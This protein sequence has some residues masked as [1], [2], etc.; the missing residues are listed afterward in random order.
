MKLAIITAA[1]KRHKLFEFFCEYYSVLKQA[2]PFELIVACS[3]KETLTLAQKYGHTALMIENNPLYLKMNAPAMKARGSDYCLMIGS[4]DFITPKMLMW[5][6]EKAQQT[7]H[8]YIYPLD[9]YFFDTKTKKGLYWAGYRQKWNTGMAC[10]AG[11]ILSKRLMD[12]L[13]WQP[14]I[15]GYDHVLDTGMD[16]LLAKLQYSSMGFYL[17]KENLFSV[18]IKTDTNMTP[19]AKWDNTVELNGTKMLLDHMPQQMTKIL[20]L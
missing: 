20:S 11:R 18:D 16:K 5:Y 19:F 17:K 4:D 1:W 14:W 3:E 15:K 8:D 12:K 13:N 10:G 9:W 7:K 2:H 6:I